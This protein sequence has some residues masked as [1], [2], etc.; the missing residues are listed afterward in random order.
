[1]SCIT[2]TLGDRAENHKGMQIIGKETKN[3]YNLNDLLDIKNKFE[4]DG[5]KCDIINLNTLLDEDKQNKV[6]PAYVLIIS[7]CIDYLLKNDNESKMNLFE[8]LVNLNWDKKALMYGRVVNKNARY[9]L[10]FSN[11]EQEPDYSNGLGRIIKWN[12]VPILNKIKTYLS[13]YINEIETSE[14]EGNYYY[15]I[16]KTGIGYH[17]DLERKKVV[18]IRVGSP[19][20]LYYQWFELKEPIGTKLKINLDGGD[21]YIMNEIAKGIKPNSLNKYVLKHSA[22]CDKYT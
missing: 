7:N 1:M 10:C 15:D 20:P 6:E 21:I 19:M 14:G 2:I 12:N 5:L 22:G 9:N 3:G 16:T 17:C 4:K 8:E 13:K 18:G 11:Q